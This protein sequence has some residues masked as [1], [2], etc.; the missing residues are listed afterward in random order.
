MRKAVQNSAVKSTAFS[1]EILESQ[2][3]RLHHIALSISNT[4]AITTPT[5][6]PKRQPGPKGHPQL[7][8]RRHTIYCL[9]SIVVR[10]RGLRR[11]SRNTEAAVVRAEHVE[12]E[13]D[14][15]ASSL[16]TQAD[17]NSDNTAVTFVES[18]TSASSSS[19]SSSPPSSAPEPQDPSSDG[20]SRSMTTTRQPLLKADED[21]N[22][23]WVLTAS[24]SCVRV[25]RAANAIIVGG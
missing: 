12:T 7:A 10:I 14:V 2:R 19:P 22:Q 25:S 24:E 15:D 4:T 1:D 18:A 16:V 6:S 20:R 9:Q 8:Q 23:E 11:L 21:E 17:W 13:T 3:Y 5:T